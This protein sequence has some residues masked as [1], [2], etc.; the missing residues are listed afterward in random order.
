MVSCFTQYAHGKNDTAIEF[1]SPT[2]NDSLNQHVRT[3]IHLD[4][5][6]KEL[7]PFA[8]Y[9]DPVFDNLTKDVFNEASIIIVT[10]SPRGRAGRRLFL[11]LNSLLT[12]RHSF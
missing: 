9:P 10:V 3:S 7:K 5:W 8:Y 4:N 6:S 11:L 2:V 1:Q 12:T